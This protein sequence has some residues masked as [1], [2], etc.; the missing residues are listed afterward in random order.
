MHIKPFLI[1]AGVLFVIVAPAW[2]ADD[3]QDVRP[4]EDF[5]RFKA[6]AFPEGW[7]CFWTHSKKAREV[8]SVQTD[9]V[10]FLVAK[11]DNCDVPI[12]KK[13]DYDVTEYPYLSWQWRVMQL[14]EGANERDKKTGDSAAGIY[15]IFQGK[16]F[17]NR[18]KY[19]WSTTLKAGTVTDSPH[20]KKTKIVVLRNASNPLG[21]WV[22]EKVNVFDDYK[23]LYGEEPKPVQGI[24]IMTDSNDTQ[25]RAEAHY[26]ALCISRN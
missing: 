18:I 21:T 20:S 15:V 12:A 6:G 3:P 25:S 13:F 14:P 16:L 17:P 1:I 11:A 5:S 7:K 23:R 8:Y 9:D 26:R 19:V 2:A 10:C 4:I 22:T 24:G